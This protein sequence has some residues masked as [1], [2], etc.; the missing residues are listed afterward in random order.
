[1][2][3]NGRWA[4]NKGLPRIS[5]HQQGMKAVRETIESALELKIPYL[6]LFGFSWENW[7][8][9][10]EE[11]DELIK[12]LTFYLEKE[13]DSLNEN[14]VCLKV[15]GDISPFN[16]SVI[17]LIKEAEKQT[18][19][20]TNLFLTVAL[21]YS[22]RRDILQATKT[23][24]HDIKTGLLTSDQINDQVFSQYLMTSTM[25]DPDLVIRTSGE[26]RISN[27]LLW[28]SAYAEFVFFDVYWPDFGKKDFTEAIALYQNRQRRYGKVSI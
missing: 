10:E 3:G 5:G 13:I 11:V 2:D 22:G 26:K 21:S 28:Q 8:R 18:S 7:K 16:Q 25:P 6:T 12:L 27:F 23:I 9:P 19:H 17:S 4:Q 1:M 15:I 14:G 24:I 20:N